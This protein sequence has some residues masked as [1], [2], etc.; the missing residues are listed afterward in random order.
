MKT[1]LAAY[2]TAAVLM[3]FAVM[4]LPLALKMSY[5]TFQLSPQSFAGERQDKLPEAYG[6]DSQSFETSSSLI[7]LIG[8][9]FAF[10]A[11]II[12]KKQV[13]PPP[14]FSYLYRP[15]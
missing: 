10:A 6:L 1:K 13:N 4:M 12:V 14:A 3:G 5:P 11:Y 9:I 2:I 7:L 15:F 8:L